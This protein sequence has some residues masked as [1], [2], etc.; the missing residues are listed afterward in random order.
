MEIHNKISLSRGNS[1]LSTNIVNF[2]I[3]PVSTCG[4]E[5]SGCYALRIYKRWKSVRKA[6]DGN[7]NESKSDDFTE[8]MINK[9]KK[10]YKSSPFDYFR[11]HVAGDFYDQK[12]LQKWIDIINSC[13]DIQFYAYTKKNTD[14]F[15]VVKIPDNFNLIYSIVTDPADKKKKMNYA[16]YPIIAELS[17]RTGYP[18]CPVTRGHDIKCGEGCITCMYEKNVLFV[19]H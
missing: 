9:I 12:Y 13:P 6:W 18:I 19:K 7:L 15:S 10:M 2:S 11:I 16:D 5:C 4:R 1:K 3:P 17:K 8:L 14:F